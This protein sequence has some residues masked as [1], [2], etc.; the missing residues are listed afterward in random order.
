MDWPIP[1]ASSETA[2]LHRWRSGDRDAGSTLLDPGGPGA[3]D[4]AKILAYLRNNLGYT[5][6]ITTDWLP[7]S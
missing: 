4:S 6:L 5:G 2:L 7:S 3:G 1:E